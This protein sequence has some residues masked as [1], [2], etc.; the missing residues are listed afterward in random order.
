MAWAKLVAEGLAR[1][2]VPLAPLTTYKLGGP[3][4]LLVEAGSEEDL[5]R[6]GRAIAEEPLPVLVLGRGSNV[7]VSDQGFPGLVLRL[8]AGFGWS[9]VDGDGMVAGAATPLPSVA[10]AAVA[11]GRLGL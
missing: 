8:G 1:Q 7:L 9:G 6:V 3:A 2:H 5:H 11:A 10:R 4:R